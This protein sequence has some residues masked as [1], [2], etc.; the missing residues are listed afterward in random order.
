MTLK[1]AFLQSAPWAILALILFIVAWAPAF[2]I[3]AEQRRQL[4]FQSLITFAI[5]VTFA[6]AGVTR[7]D[8]LSFNE[9]YLLEVLPLTAVAFGWALN[10]YR[11]RSMAD[12]GRRDW[13]R[14]RVAGVARNT[15]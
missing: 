14:A 7:H 15:G 1:K 2:R 11:S 3:P 13:R 8:G 9:R 4:R 5:L 12:R 10:S 6:A